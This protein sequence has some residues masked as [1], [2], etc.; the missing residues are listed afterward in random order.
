MLVCNTSSIIYNTNKVAFCT[1]YDL[2][3]LA[4]TIGWNM[5][6]PWYVVSNTNFL[7]LYICFGRYRTK[8][9]SLFLSSVSLSTL[10]VSHCAKAKKKYFILT[11]LMV[12]AAIHKMAIPR[13][14]THSP[15]RQ[16]AHITNAFSSCWLLY[17]RK[18]VE[19]FFGLISIHSI[20]CCYVARPANHI[21]RQIERN[22]TCFFVCFYRIP[23]ILSGACL[24]QHADR[25]W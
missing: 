7:Y 16:S 15:V 10:S 3:W 14:H 20:F 18:V 17:Y 22:L 12:I 1:W 19:L 11:T 13:T 4:C 24:A 25:T 23:L 8:G 2:V 6:C 9:F 5:T 21:Q